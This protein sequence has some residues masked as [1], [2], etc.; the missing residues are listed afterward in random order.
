[1]ANPLVTVS[2]YGDMLKVIKFSK[3][4]IVGRD[5][6]EWYKGYFRRLKSKQTI[7]Q[8]QNVHRAKRKINEY[9]TICTHVIKNPAF[10]TFTYAIPQH[11]IQ[12]AIQDW[13]DFTRKIK[14]HWPQVAFLRVP[15]RHKT[16]AVHFHA[17][18]FG[19]PPKLACTMQ[20]R[21]K[22]WIHACGTEKLCE[23]HLRALAG[24]WG[25]GFVD[26]S[27]ARKPEAL[28]VYIS[29]YLT[30]GDPDWTLFGSHVYSVNTKM[31]E[32]LRK[33]KKDG[34]YYR[35]TSHSYATAVD[36]ILEDLKPKLSL[37]KTGQFPTYWLG[38]AT[39]QLYKIE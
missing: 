12:K 27:R 19:L 33:A 21:G 7:K 18:M 24:L 11:D 36:M 29:K 10:A 35:I 23:R 2:R 8:S 26:L 37:L 20:K 6:R 39:F 14:K 9:I 3:E 17:V 32:V 13:R 1:M 38:E 34:I 30:K 16:G 22:R 15:E 31:F 4:L 25:K 5:S 28:G